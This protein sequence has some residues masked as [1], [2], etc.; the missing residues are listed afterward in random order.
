MAG[1]AAV[2]YALLSAWPYILF[3]VLPF[4]AAS[5][6][7]AGIFWLATRPSDTS[8]GEVQA[9]YRYSED[10]C[11]KP[12]FQYRT[13][14]CV[15]FPLLVVVNLGVFHLGASGALVVEVDRKGKIQRSYPAIEWPAVNQA[16]NETRRGAYADSWFDSLKRAAQHDEIYDRRDIGGIFW[17]ALVVGGPLIFLWWF[18]AGDELEESKMLYKHLEKAIKHEKDVLRRHIDEH[19]SIVKER[20]KPHLAEIA[21]LKRVRAT[22]AEENQ[23][24]KAK[25]EFS[26]DV[27]KPP[28]TAKTSG[29]LDSDI[30]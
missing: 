19:E 17:L 1:V 10:K 28:E 15:V 13:L 9:E 18:G 25:V 2:I 30:L 27:P 12:L 24:L 3:Y 22:L 5:F 11:Y 16:F 14:A 26:K 8:A 6:L 23:V 21:E 7:Y 29:V 4:I 20:I